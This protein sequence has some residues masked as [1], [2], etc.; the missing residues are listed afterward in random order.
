MV[1]YRYTEIIGEFSLPPIFHITY[2]IIKNIIQ[3]NQLIHIY[4]IINKYDPEEQ[5]GNYHQKR[6]R[7]NYHYFVLMENG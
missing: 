7:E 2:T 1:I 4:I 6:E 3:V 5:L